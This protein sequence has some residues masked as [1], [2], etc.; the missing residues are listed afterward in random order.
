MC[1]FFFLLENWLKWQ[2]KSLDLLINKKT[3][4]LGIFPMTYKTQFWTDTHDRLVLD[5]NSFFEDFPLIQVLSCML[6]RS[7]TL[8]TIVTDY[9]PLNN[10]WWTKSRCCYG[11]N[12]ILRNKHIF[13]TQY[14]CSKAS[15]KLCTCIV[16]TLFRS[17]LQDIT[18][19]TVWPCVFT[20]KSLNASWPSCTR[21]SLVRCT[22][23]Y[24]KVQ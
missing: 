19:V 6:L 7:C 23:S 22:I 8:Q 18:N 17:L 15:V 20:K 12:F 9:T 10:L 2:F 24:I 11:L 16:T 4:I 5:D 13:C 14:L 1:L 3:C 21:E